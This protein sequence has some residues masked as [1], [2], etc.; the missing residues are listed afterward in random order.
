[1]QQTESHLYCLH[2]TDADSD[3]EVRE[4]VGKEYV[5]GVLYYEVDWCTTVLPNPLEHAKDLVDEFEAWL[6][7]EDGVKKGRGR[8]GLE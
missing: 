2:V 1:M 8:A 5:D 3:C 6:R 7:G 4:I